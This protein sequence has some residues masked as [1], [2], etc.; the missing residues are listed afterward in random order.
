MSFCVTAVFHFNSAQ[1]LRSLIVFEVIYP[2]TFLFIV[3]A[4][5]LVLDRLMDFCKLKESLAS[6]RLRQWNLFERVSVGS[7]VACNLVGLCGNIS[8]SVHQSKA[9][10]VFDFLV[11][12]NATVDKVIESDSFDLIMQATK[13]TAIYMGLETVILLLI[14]IAFVCVIIASARRFRAYVKSAAKRQQVSLVDQAAFNRL[15]RQISVTC[16]VVL[17]SFFLR[18]VYT[19]TSTTAAALLNSSDE[20]EKYTN[21]CSACYNTFTHIFVWLLYTPGVFFCIAIISQPI[22]LL[23]ALWG[24]TSQQTLVIMGQSRQE[25]SLAAMREDS[26]K[27]HLKGSSDV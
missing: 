10:D 6:S 21:R 15:R 7:I 18:A 1:A 2:F 23:V 19:T 22:P 25:I 9:A 3:V 4:K 27:L 5:L 14:V 26:V 16:I 24:M 11:A 13:L 17:L 20:C 8:A 12:N